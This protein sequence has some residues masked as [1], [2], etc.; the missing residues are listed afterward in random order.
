MSDID[1]ASAK[2]AAEKIIERRIQ[3]ADA[4]RFGDSKALEQSQFLFNFECGVRGYE[5]AV[6]YQ[7]LYEKQEKTDE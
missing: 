3:L 1:H 4:V 7:D 6:A 2:Q 5:L